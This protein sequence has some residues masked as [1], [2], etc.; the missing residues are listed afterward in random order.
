MIFVNVKLFNIN[1]I[2]AKVSHFKQNDSTDCGPSCLRMIM[3]YYG[4]SMDLLHLREMCFIT[5]EGVSLLSVAEAA[6][7]LGFRTKGIR[8][9]C[10][11]L[12][13]EDFCKS[14]FSNINEEEELK[15]RKELD[16]KRFT[17]LSHN[18]SNTLELIEGIHYV[19]KVKEKN[20]YLRVLCVKRILKRSF[21]ILN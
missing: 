6:E 8:I 19:S 21:F 16:Y 18:Q 4:K 14:W 20:I 12:A 2:N 3:K 9:S 17:K 5:C 7:S 1:R 11:Q 10:P 13:K 15:K